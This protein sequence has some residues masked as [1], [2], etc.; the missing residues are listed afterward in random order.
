MLM[1]YWV[2]AVKSIN[3]M[4]FENITDWH[5]IVDYIAEFQWRY[6]HKYTNRCGKELAMNC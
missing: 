4:L 2:Y 6:S 5:I 3:V 1:Y